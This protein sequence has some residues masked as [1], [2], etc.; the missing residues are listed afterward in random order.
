MTNTVYLT[1]HGQS[2]NNVKKIIGGDCALSWEG[3]KY[4]KRLYEYFRN[5]ENLNETK[6]YTSNLRRTKQTGIYFSE[7]NKKTFSFLNEINAGD[8]ENFTY[9]EIKMN[10]PE[11]FK[12]REIDKFN[13]KYPN[14][15]SYKDLKKR[16]IHI[17]KYI[18]QDFS[19]NKNCLI[20][21]HNAVLRILYG[22]LKNIP[23][24]EVPFLEIPLHVLFKFENINN[25]YKLTMIELN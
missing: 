20:I 9:Q 5:N 13:Y 2:I 22:V 4:S 17:L 6:I 21:C 7:E 19:N 15:E 14:G 24:K 11:E 3:Q 1:R 8:F 25:D 23:D 16:A 10:Y 12:K 18:N